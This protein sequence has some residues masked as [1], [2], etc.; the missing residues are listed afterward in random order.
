MPTPIAVVSRPITKEDLERTSAIAFLQTETQTQSADSSGLWPDSGVASEEDHIRK[1]GINSV[2]FPSVDSNEFDS[3]S[4]E[5]GS[6][7]VI[8]R[9]AVL[10]VVG[11]V[12]L[13]HI[14]K[15]WMPQVQQ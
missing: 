3:P 2:V 6:G 13:N 1:E 12:G 11:L 9:V 7:I 4:N 5:E 8:K 10:R 14:G 15:K